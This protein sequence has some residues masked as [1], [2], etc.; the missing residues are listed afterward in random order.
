MARGNSIGLY[1][2]FGLVEGLR[3]MRG[4]NGENYAAG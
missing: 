2:L 3:Y 1:L 4:K